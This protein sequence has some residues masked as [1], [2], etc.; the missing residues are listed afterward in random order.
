MNRIAYRGSRRE[1]GMSLVEAALA[2]VIMGVAA[3]MS[4]QGIKGSAQRGDQIEKQAQFQRAE[5]ALIAFIALNNQ[6]PCPA[7]QPNGWADCSQVLANR[8]RARM[9]FPYRTVGIPE[10]K[11]AHMHYEPYDVNA[12]PRREFA[13]GLFH[14]RLNDLE[15]SIDQGPRAQP[16]PL[17]RVASTTYDGILDTCDALARVG[18]ARINAF[19]LEQRPND[20]LLLSSMRTMR[21]EV[22][23]AQ[24]SDHM[25]CGPLASIGGRSQYHAHLAS[26]IMNKTMK[27]YKW[28]FEADYGTYN[29]DLAEAAFFMSTKIYGELMRWPKTI[30]ALSKFFESR[31]SDF[32]AIRMMITSVINQA[33]S[34][35]SVAAQ[36]SNVG[37]FVTNLEAARARYRVILDLNR[38]A[39][40]VYVTAWQNAVLSSSSAY[41]LREQSQLPPRPAPLG[42]VATDA[43]NPIAQDMID[44]A[45][46]R[47]NGFGASIVSAALQPLPIMAEVAPG[48]SIDFAVEGEPLPLLETDAP[49]R[50][51]SGDYV[52]ETED[53]KS[54]IDLDFG[55]KP[56][57]KTPTKEE[58]KRGDERTQDL[59][60]KLRDEAAKRAEK[61][62]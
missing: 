7:S 44:Q 21:H 46:N 4:W 12:L 17:Q 60:D 5:A 42:S 39:D 55:T 52:R 18:D 38:R 45:R 49:N 25:S 50:E 16:T 33:A 57:A 53:V 56:G 48:S 3:T 62:K 19:T 13:N 8:N 1:R 36:A 23:A 40:E 20:D 27:E 30:Q 9:Y 26:A 29:L 31:F 41:F 54:D 58:I 43:V 61:R 34:T 11:M 35:A 15:I 6:L 51:A 24:V 47:A 10:P 32:N 59:E 14:V 37:R 22:S 28:I 2:M